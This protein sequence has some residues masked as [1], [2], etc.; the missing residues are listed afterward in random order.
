MASDQGN[1][2]PVWGGDWSPYDTDGVT[3]VEAWEK[4]DAHEFLATQFENLSTGSTVS[5]TFMDQPRQ[6]IETIDENGKD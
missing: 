4:V 1:Y 2:T 6:K 3:P 5:Y